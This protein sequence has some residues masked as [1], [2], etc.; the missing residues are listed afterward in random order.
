MRVRL[1]FF[2]KVRKAIG[3]SVA[4]GRRIGRIGGAA[5]LR[6]EGVGGAGDSASAGRGEEDP[7][8]VGCGMLGRCAVVVAGAAV[9]LVWGLVMG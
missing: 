8:S 6:V 3:R 9:P 1:C 4:G 5:G 7:A 2:V